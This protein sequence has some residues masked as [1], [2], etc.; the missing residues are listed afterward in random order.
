MSL[1]V[2]SN[3]K[4]DSCGSDALLVPSSWSLWWSDSTSVGAFTQSV[5]E[6]FVFSLMPTLGLRC[7][8]G[9][10]RTRTTHVRWSEA[11]TPGTEN[12]TKL[13]SCSATINRKHDEKC[14]LLSESVTVCT[15]CRFKASWMTTLILS[16]CKLFGRTSQKKRFRYYRMTHQRHLSFYIW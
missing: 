4:L 9:S 8:T 6:E 12:R 16:G 3:N 13:V 11:G 10:I 5:C 2:W 14:Q 15:K 1:I 7:K